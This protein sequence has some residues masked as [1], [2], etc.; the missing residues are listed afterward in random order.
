LSPLV[1]AGKRVRC[2][3]ITETPGAA[4][5]QGAPVVRRLF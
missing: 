1:A 4:R 5:S 2:R 3:L